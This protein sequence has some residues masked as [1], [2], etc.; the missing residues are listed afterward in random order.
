MAEVIHQSVQKAKKRYYDDGW[1]FFSNWLSDGCSCDFQKMRLDRKGYEWI[2]WRPSF[3]DY[4]TIIKI[5]NEGHLIQPGMLYRR[6][7][8]RDGGDTWTYRTREELYQLMA[9][10]RLFEDN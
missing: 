4:R 5:R 6:Q 10:Y 3:S 2:K 9:K 1:E 8:N 7:F